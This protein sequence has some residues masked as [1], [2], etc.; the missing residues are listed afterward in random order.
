MAE[1]TGIVYLIQPEELLLT[2]RYKIGCS[3]KKGLSRLSSYKKNTRYICTMECKNPFELET[4]LKK[5]FNEKYKLI[6]G[7]E[8]FEGI[9]NEIF[10]YFINIAQTYNNTIYH[11]HLKEKLECC[12]DIVLDYVQNK[13]DEKNVD[14]INSS[15]QFKDMLISMAYENNLIKDKE[16]ID[17][18]L[19]SDMA[20][21]ALKRVIKNLGLHISDTHSDVKSIM[22]E[23]YNKYCND[24]EFQTEYIKN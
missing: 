19:N 17:G 10:N 4:I 15:E 24:G 21:F 8:Y 6:A 1:F 18:Y 23:V 3:N 13:I 5:K 20:I 7:K 2:N 11:S 22:D 16:S 12:S 14:V 9:E